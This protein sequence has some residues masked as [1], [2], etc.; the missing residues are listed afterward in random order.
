MNIKLTSLFLKNFKGI[1]ELYMEF[2]SNIVNIL[3]KEMN[4]HFQFMYDDDV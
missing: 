4:E 2:N 3:A 1:E